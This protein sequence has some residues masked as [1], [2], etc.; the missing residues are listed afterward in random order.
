[1]TVNFA[2]LAMDQ[3]VITWRRSVPCSAAKPICRWWC[4]MP[5]GVQPVGG[6]HSQSLESYFMHCPGM[7]VAYQ[8]LRPMQGAAQD[9]HP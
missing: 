8:P 5:V 1:M 4:A 7:R 6:Q 9:R 3:L 2:L